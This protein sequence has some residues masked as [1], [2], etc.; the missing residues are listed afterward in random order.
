MPLSKMN[1]L[2]L[3]FVLALVVIS[4]VVV[5]N[6]YNNT[7][8]QRLRAQARRAKARWDS[9]SPEYKTRIKSDI[10]GIRG[11]IKGLWNDVWG[12]YDV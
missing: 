4:A 9:S 10:H 1:N 6:A 12:K 2:I 3:F 7:P 5:W 11:D 8:Y